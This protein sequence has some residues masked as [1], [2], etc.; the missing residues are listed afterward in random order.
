[1]MLRPEGHFL[2]FVIWNTRLIHL[3]VFSFVGLVGFVLLFNFTVPGHPSVWEI[4]FIT[5]LFYFGKGLSYLTLLRI[6]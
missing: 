6:L 5:E 2:M 4:L 3:M 1:M